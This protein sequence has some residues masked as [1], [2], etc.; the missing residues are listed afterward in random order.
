MT[1]LLK[2][3]IWLKTN[4]LIIKIFVIPIVDRLLPHQSGVMMGSTL[5]STDDRSNGD[6][7]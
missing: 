2:Y 4:P 7:S 5:S 3:D 6:D 1:A